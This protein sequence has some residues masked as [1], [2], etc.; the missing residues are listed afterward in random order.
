MENEEK[1]EGKSPCRRKNQNPRR[2]HILE[3]W[4]KQV[5]QEM[6]DNWKDLGFTSKQQME[7]AIRENLYSRRSEAEEEAWGYREDWS[8]TSDYPMYRKNTFQP[9]KEEGCKGG[10][11]VKWKPLTTWFR[12][13][14]VG[15]GRMQDGKGRRRITIFM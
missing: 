9:N 11:M 8:L 2:N 7:K 13:A 6:E 14:G 10:N 12:Q 4:E 1:K 5:P 15:P 3:R